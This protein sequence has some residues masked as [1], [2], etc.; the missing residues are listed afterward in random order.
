MGVQHTHTHTFS[1]THS[2]PSLSGSYSCLSSPLTRLQFLCTQTH[3]QYTDKKRN[4]NIS[5]FKV[6]KVVRPDLAL[7]S[8]R[9]SSPLG[10]Y[11]S[12]QLKRGPFVVGVRHVQGL[13][14]IR[15]ESPENRVPVGSK[16]PWGF[17]SFSG[18]LRTIVDPIF[19]SIDPLYCWKSEILHWFTELK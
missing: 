8:L 4:K 13:D 14:A 16:E 12:L 5:S 19:W 9:S 15:R 2:P 7:N 3:F 18:V 11:P 17:S 1:F 6:P 10:P